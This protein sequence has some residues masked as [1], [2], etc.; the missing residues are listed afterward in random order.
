MFTDESGLLMAPL[1]RTT[2]APRGHTPALPV[3]GRHR[4]KVSVAAALWKTPGR[5][6]ARV[7]YRTYPNGHVGA[8]SYAEFLEELLER[9]LP[10]GPAVVVHDGGTTHRGEPV[11]SLADDFDRLLGLHLLPPY[12]PMLNPVEQLWDWLKYDELPNFAPEDVPHLDAAI[13]DRLFGLHHDQPRLR[14]F[15]ASTPLRW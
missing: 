9:R 2:L 6:L 12:A 15:L 5:G 14:T 8:G 13:N 4:E 1:R 3:R 7:H 10:R 11:E